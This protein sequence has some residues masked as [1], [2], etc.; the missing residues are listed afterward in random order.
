MY[1]KDGFLISLRLTSAALMLLVCCG[2]A[3]AQSSAKKSSAPAPAKAP[4]AAKA[5]SAAS[6]P[7][8]A[9]AP[10]HTGPTT[11]ST[12]HGG[13]TTSNAGHGGVT[14]NNA[15]H[16]A[17]TT[18]PGRTTGAA[19]PA[20]TPTTTGG[21]PA[22]LAGGKSITAAS[23]RPTP[24]GTK[25]VRTPAGNT[26]TTRANGKPADVHVASRGM[27]IHHNLNGSRR[28][29]VE[30]ADHSRIVAER[31]GRGYVQ[32]PYTYGGREFHQRTYYYNGRVYD[33]YYQPYYYRG[34]YVN[35]Y[36]PAYYYRPAFYGWAYNPWAAPIA[37]NWGWGGNPWY[38]YYGYYFTPYQVYPSASVWLTDYLISNAL[39]SAYQAQANAAA[40]VAASNAQAVADAAALTPQVKDMIAAEVQRQIALENAES[41]QATQNAAADPASSGIQRMLT[42]N[43]Q[44]IFVVGHDLDVVDASG[45][46]CAVSDGDAIQLSGP[47][48]ADATA[49]SLIVLASKGARECRKGATISVAVA[50]LQE[51]QNH[52]RET[53]DQ[54]MG[55]LQTKQ[56]KGGL[57]ALPPSASAPPVKAAFVSSAPPPD[58][59]AAA[60]I[61]QQSQEAD[62]AENQTL[63]EAKRSSGPG[64]SDSLAQDNGAAPAGPPPTLALGQTIEEVTA[65]EGPPK[66]VVD[67]GAKKIYLFSHYKVTFKDGKVSNVE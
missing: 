11:A 23:S 26:V 54:G 43:I 20:H 49:A 8:G 16:G 67:L 57:P 25:T 1:F 60:E 37:Y 47:T 18:N 32:R 22:T 64:P 17:S 34:V 9:A 46:E 51:M 61:K 40:A 59:N 21:R 52:M 44:H 28:V 66:S 33:R 56:S 39:A 27:D 4:A 38:G 3:D 62:Q 6:K 45:A 53:I 63:A 50:D 19:T 29:E 35:V 65:I 42:D 15:G 7:G 58:S 48:P 2:V 14:T 12:A 10:G 41:A 30:R 5:P 55:E 24:V 31:G 13:V 36:S